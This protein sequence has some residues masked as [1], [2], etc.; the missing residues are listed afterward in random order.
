MAGVASQQAVTPTLFSPEALDLTIRE[1]VWI[2][3]H[4]EEL[5]LDNSCRNWS[6][7]TNPTQKFTKVLRKD[8]CFWHHMREG[9]VFVSRMVDGHKVEF[10]YSLRHRDFSLYCPFSREEHQ[11]GN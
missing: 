1:V 9:D 11:A 2:A 5:Q 7:P 10:L 6:D 8:T 3:R 4:I